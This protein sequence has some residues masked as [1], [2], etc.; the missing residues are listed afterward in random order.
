[1]RKHFALFAVLGLL[2]AGIANAQNTVTLGASVTTGDGTLTT[3]VTWSTNPPLTTGTP[4]TATGSPQWAG[5][6]AGSGSQSITIATSGTLNLALTCRFPGDS[7]V[8]FTWTNAT[9][10]TDNSAYTNPKAVRLVY[11]FDDTLALTLPTQ[12]C[13]GAVVCVDVPDAIGSRPTVKTV[14]GITQTGTLRALAKHVNQNDATSAASNA[15]SK[16]F[17]GSVDVTQTVV[18]TVNPLPAAPTGFGAS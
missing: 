9:V 12:P 6:K 10:N 18:L 8:T 1:M 17:S 5:M 15:A 14:T 2:A 11:T 7:I 3:D 13:G 16:M 4:C